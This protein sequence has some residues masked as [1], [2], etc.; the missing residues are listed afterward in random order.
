MSDIFSVLLRSVSV[1]YKGESVLEA[2]HSKT[3]VK[4]GGFLPVS[5]VESE[6]VDG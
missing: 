6:S 5:D 4:V 2:A 1:K 3:T